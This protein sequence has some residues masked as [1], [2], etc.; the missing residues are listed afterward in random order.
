MRAELSQLLS[1]GRTENC[2][3]GW[4]KQQIDEY[5]S[6]ESTYGPLKMLEVPVAEIIGKMEALPEMVYRRCCNRI[7]YFRE[8]LDEETFRRKLKAMKRKASICIDCVQ[9]QESEETDKHCRS[10]HE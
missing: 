4:N 10:K 7:G 8:P 6:L 3:C 5:K 2:G 1:L 9:G